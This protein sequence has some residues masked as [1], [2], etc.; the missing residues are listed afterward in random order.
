MWFK[1]KSVEEKASLVQ[2]IKQGLGKTSQGFVNFW[3][4]E[5]L[6]TKALQ[7]LED[8]LM[9][10]DLGPKLAVQ[11][12]EDLGKKKFEDRAAGQAFLAQ[13]L[14]EYLQKNISA[15]PFVWPPKN[16]NKPHVVLML[17]VNG[18]G[19]TTTMAKLAEKA[20][21]A[22]QKVQL[23]A[24]DTFRAAA[25]EQLQVWAN[26]VGASFFSKG[27]GADAAA[28]AFE[29]V[30]DAINNKAD[31][32]IIDTAGRLHNQNNL[33]DELAKVVRVLQKLDNAYPHQVLLTL[34]ATT[35]QNAVTQA[36]AF[37]QTVPVT[38]IIPT[39]L[40]G[41]AKAGFLWPLTAALPHK[42]LPFIGVGEGAH[43]L[44]PFNATEFAQSILGG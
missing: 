41:S 13:T 33:M 42:Q 30:Q 9:M 5:K 24:A 31:L 36:V 28:T 4:H 23:V 39:K 19:K 44:V 12:V 38:A 35:G 29:G 40:D 10:A 1:K 8:L 27:L 37:N 18:S 21:Q 14:A 17:G 3:T 7:E 11:L 32:V 26:R 25:V 43:D 22:G 16:A 34:D 15:E 6:D 20:V 2:K